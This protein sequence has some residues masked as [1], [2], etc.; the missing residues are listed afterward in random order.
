M[1]DGAANILTFDSQAVDEFISKYPEARPYIKP[2]YGGDEFVS[3]EPS[4]CLWITSDNV[5]EALKIGGIR[6][7]V[8][9][10]RQKRAKS[11]SGKKARRILMHLEN[12]ML[13]AKGKSLL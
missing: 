7:R 6:D 10:V 3:G 9:L 8:E 2:L 5:K 12:K 4:W 11:T 13:L 1:P